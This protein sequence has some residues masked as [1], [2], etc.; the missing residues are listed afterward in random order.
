M[1]ANIWAWRA[2]SHA[3]DAHSNGFFDNCDKNGSCSVDIITDDHPETAYGPG[4]EFDINTLEE[5]HVKVNFNT[6]ANGDFSDYVIKL[7][8]GDRTVSLV[9]NCPSD[10]AKMTED[11]RSGMVFAMSVWEGDMSWLQHDRCSGSCS[12]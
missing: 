1:E 12:Q 6:D 7:T 4:A 5:F 10:L 9:A 3:C 11:L 8:Q 2:T